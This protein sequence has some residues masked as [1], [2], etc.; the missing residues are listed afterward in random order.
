MGVGGGSAK[1]TEIGGKKEDSAMAPESL[2]AI[3]MHFPPCGLRI[4]IVIALTAVCASSPFPKMQ[5]FSLWAF[6]YEAIFEN[7]A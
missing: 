5:W 3:V 1:S 4:S 6:L 7:V 2:A